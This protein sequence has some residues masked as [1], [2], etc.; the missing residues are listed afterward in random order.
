[1]TTTLNKQISRAYKGLAHEIERRNADADLAEALRFY[2]QREAA[3]CEV[4]GVPP[5]GNLLAEVRRIKEALELPIRPAAEALPAVTAYRWWSAKQV[6]QESGVS[7]STVCRRAGEIEGA[8]QT[9]NGV[10]HFP[11]G[12]KITRKRRVV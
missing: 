3:M 10:W 4:L 9:A 1:M 6:A 11:V 7:V 12:S 5:G 8:V 2:Q